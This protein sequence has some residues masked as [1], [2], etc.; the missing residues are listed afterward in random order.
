MNFRKLLSLLLAAGVMLGLALPAL[1]ERETYALEF[2]NAAWRY[3]AEGD[4]YWQVGVVYC[5]TPETTAYESLGIYVPGAYLAATDNGDGTYTCQ[6]NEQG[7]VNGYTARTAPIVMP[8][9]TAGYSAQSAP[10]SYNGGFQSYLDAGFVYVYAGCRGR[11]NGYN[12]D[13]SLSYN[14]G[15]PW[16]ATDLKAAVRY[17]RYNA[18]ILPGDASRI[19]TFGHSGGGAQSA[20]MGATGD[21]ALYTPYLE[22]IGAAMT[23]AQGNQL[24]DAICGAMCWCPITS[25]DAADAA[26]EWNMGQYSDE[27][28]R[29]DGSF[30]GA[31]SD[32][33]AAAYADYLNGLDLR[34]EAGNALTL[35]AS[36]EG[37]YAAGS[38]YEYLLAQIERSLN[39]FLSDTAFPYTSGGGFMADGGFPGGGRPEGGFPDGDMPQGER[40][41]GDMPQGDAP[42]GEARQD[43]GQGGG[44]GMAAGGEAATYATAQD[45]IDA[46]NEGGAWIEYDAESNAAKIASIEDF[47]THCKGASKSVGAFDDLQRGQAENL[48]FGT[49]DSDA[50][51]FDQTMADLLAANQEEYAAYEDWNAAYVEEYRQDLQSV[52]ALGVDSQTRQDMYNPMYYLLDAYEGGGSSSVAPHWRIRTGIAQGDTA[53][54]VETNLALALSQLED[55]EDVDF[56][57]VWDQGHTMAERSLSGEENFIAWV[58]ACCPA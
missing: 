7:A 14:G 36:A 1:A 58:A 55:V 45:Y 13:G 10:T 2:D 12:E 33:L 32:D 24:S 47:V 3:D 5:A 9:N 16:G 34:D 52:D 11:S 18:G 22:S 20:L 35:A 37:I 31:L 50:R 38:Y 17:L 56:A 29:A 19:F 26:Y 39:N 15:A 44:R 28:A 41:Q 54:T 8:V 57:M 6:V 49:A 4:V 40:P 27:G 42:Q 43:R 51:H 53:L 25:L 30:T 48:V 23:D 21:S 46:L